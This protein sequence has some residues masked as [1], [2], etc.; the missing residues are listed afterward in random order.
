MAVP[1]RFDPPEPSADP[2]PRCLMEPSP[3]EGLYIHFPFCVSL[4]PYCDFVVMAGAAARGPANR[5]D[6]LL[7]AVHRELGL[8]ADTLDERFGVRRTPLT[9]VYVGGGTPSLLT[10]AQVGRLLAHVDERSVQ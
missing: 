10:A 8:R 5:I 3:P 7:E 2:G 9:S 1:G 4:C 6:A